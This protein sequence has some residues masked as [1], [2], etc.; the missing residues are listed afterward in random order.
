MSSKGQLGMNMHCHPVLSRGAVRL[1][2]AYYIFQNNLPFNM[3]RFQKDPS[4]FT[5]PLNFSE[6]AQSV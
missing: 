3:H 1:G 6:I 4:N 5:G 2:A